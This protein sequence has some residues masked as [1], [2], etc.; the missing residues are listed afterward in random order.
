MTTAAVKAAA[1]T[2][3][4]CF[5]MDRPRVGVAFSTFNL[6]RTD[7]TVIHITDGVDSHQFFFWVT[8]QSVSALLPE[9]SVFL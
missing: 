8:P 7:P 6:E 5:F 1:V 3:K 2:I 4:I 9:K